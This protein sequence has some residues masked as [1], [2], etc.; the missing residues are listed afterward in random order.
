[1][2]IRDFGKTAALFLV[3][4]VSF[5]SVPFILIHFSKF[6]EEKEPFFDSPVLTR[7]DNTLI[8]RSDSNGKGAFAASRNGKRV[9]K[10]IDFLSLVGEPVFASKSGR[11]IFAGED[12]GYGNVIEILHPDGLA[13]RY[14]HLSRVEVGLGDW[15][16]QRAVIGRVGKTGNADDPK[17][18]PHLHFEIRFEGGALN[19]TRGLLDPSLT[20]KK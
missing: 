7:L 10:G 18:L 9:H 8:V 5:F 17:I 15:V 20:I 12:K 3:G 2:I 16:R 11:V 1:M 13:S 6:F 19:P 14:A 4:A